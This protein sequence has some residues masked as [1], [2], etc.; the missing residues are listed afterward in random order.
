MFG[1]RLANVFSRWQPELHVEPSF[2]SAN[3]QGARNEES[4]EVKGVQTMKVS[5][6]SIS[7]ITITCIVIF[8]CSS[9]LFAGTNFSG[10]IHFN[11]G[12]PQGD[13]KD[14]IDRNAYGIGGQF[15]YAPQKSPLA[16]GIELGW[17]N[18][19]NESRREPFS[20][21][22]P[23]VTVNVETSN[24]IAQAFLVLRGRTPQGPIQLYGDAIIGLNY[25]FTETKITDSDLPGD[26]IASTVNSDDAAFAYGFG[27]GILVPVFTRSSKTRDGRPLQVSIDGGVRYVFGDEAEY[28]KKGSI[29]R[30]DGA[31]IYDPVKS[32]TDMM[33]MHIGVMISF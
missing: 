6:K 21:T 8:C 3:G 1:I 20:M 18:Y 26:D 28:L 27:G 11:T 32:K 4:N 17:M 29:R 25:L 10:G 14:Q 13:L 24:N 5:I 22:I 23:D 19:G 31:V 7:V 33:R 15:F 16:I 12:F 2:R 9:I 30:V